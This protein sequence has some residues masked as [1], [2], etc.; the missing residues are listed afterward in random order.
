M[1]ESDDDDIPEVYPELIDNDD[2]FYP[3]LRKSLV[4][5]VVGLV[6]Y[7]TEASTL[8]KEDERR[9]CAPPVRGRVDVLPR[10]P[11]QPSSRASPARLAVCAARSCGRS[12]WIVTATCVGV[13]QTKIKVE[14]NTF[15]WVIV[16]AA[17]RCTPGE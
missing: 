13:G 7:L 12:S 17:A 2:I 16:D 1:D 11:L 4:V 8:W 14:K 10:S 3:K 6:L 5:P 15:D 9:G